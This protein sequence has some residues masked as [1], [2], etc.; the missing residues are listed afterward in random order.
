[1]NCETCNRS[2]YR[3]EGI[4]VQAMDPARKNSPLMGPVAG[5]ATVIMDQANQ[6]CFW[7]DQQFEDGDEVTCEGKS[8]ECSF[9]QWVKHR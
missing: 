5:E 8:Y 9:G 1:M 4:T 3:Y 6:V 7:N 2:G